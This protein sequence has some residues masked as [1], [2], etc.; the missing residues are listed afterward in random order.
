MARIEC[1]SSE[2]GTAEIQNGIGRAQLQAEGAAMYG[3]LVEWVGVPA[4][5][6]LHLQQG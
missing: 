1:V 4:Y 3:S 5:S 2:E 6:S